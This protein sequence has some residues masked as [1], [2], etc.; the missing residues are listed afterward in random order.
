MSEEIIN[1]YSEIVTD[2][3]TTGINLDETKKK[4]LNEQ[5]KIEHTKAAYWQLYR[6]ASKRD[7]LIMSIGTIFAIISGAAIVSKIT[8][9]YA[10]FSL[11]T[12]LIIFNESSI[13]EFLAFYNC[14]IR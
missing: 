13:L 4:I 12:R 5:V 8:I 9:Y 1:D 11:N 2:N 10:I 7:W 14:H 3:E 6:F